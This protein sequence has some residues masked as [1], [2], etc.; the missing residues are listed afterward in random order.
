MKNKFLFLNYVDEDELP[1]LYINSQIVV[2]PTF[3]PPRLKLL[4]WENH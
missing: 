1:Y 4:K 2:F 3:I